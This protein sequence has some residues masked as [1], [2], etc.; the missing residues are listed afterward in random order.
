VYNRFLDIMK[1]IESHAIDTSEVASRIANLFYDAPTVIADFNMFMPPGWKVE[2][3]IEGDSRTARTVSLEGTIAT[4]PPSNHY[5]TINLPQI[6]EISIVHLLACW[7]V[8]QAVYA[9]R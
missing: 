5:G 3:S 1:D 7:P 2:C 6:S 8:G 9:A 4:I